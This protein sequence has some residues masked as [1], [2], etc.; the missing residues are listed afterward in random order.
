MFARLLTITNDKKANYT[1]EEMEKYFN[2]Y[3]FIINISTMGVQNPQHSETDSTL[4]VRKDMNK[5]ITKRIKY[6]TI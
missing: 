4:N 1:T 5:L 3:E 6:F 2:A